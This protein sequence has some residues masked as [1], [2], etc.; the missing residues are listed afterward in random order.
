MTQR[1]HA[2]LLTGLT[3]SLILVLA[4][5][6]FLLGASATGAAAPVAVTIPLAFVGGILALLSPCSGMLLPAFFAYAFDQPRRLLF[7]TYTFYLG[8]ATVFVPLGFASSLLARSL[9]AAP[10]TLY[11]VGGVMLLAMGALALAPQAAARLAPARASSLLDRAQA[12]PIDTW[13]PYLL[14]MTFGLATTSCIAPI[15]GGLTAIAAT[16]G[17]SALQSIPL[18]LAF[19]LGIA[20]P[21]FILALASR[22]RAASFARRWSV[23]TMTLPWARIPLA[24][25]V[26]GILLLALGALFLATRGTLSLTA[27]YDRTGATELAYRASLFL[28][29]RPDIPVLVALGAIL[30][31]AVAAWRSRQKGPSGRRE[32]EDDALDD[33]ARD[34]HTQEGA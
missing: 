5:S 17:V 25:A 21:L 3:G 14:G 7:A 29:A 23:R 1:R 6:G 8:L 12:S 33:E 24:Q 20:T 11:L 19:A 31:V 2:L 4:A 30:T 15:L 22:R 10:D 9:R 18:F 28:L 26:T 34:R 16:G 32:D 13:R 27:W